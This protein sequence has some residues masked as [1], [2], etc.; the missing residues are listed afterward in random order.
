MRDSGSKRGEQ[1]D[2][3]DGYGPQGKS[4]LGFECLRGGGAA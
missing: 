3:C 4:G 1:A 2:R